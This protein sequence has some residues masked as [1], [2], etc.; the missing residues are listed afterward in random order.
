MGGFP[1]SAG[2]SHGKNEKA[3][4]GLQAKNILGSL[5]ACNEHKSEHPGAEV[6][7]DKVVARG[8]GL[9]QPKVPWQSH[10]AHNLTRRCQ[11]PCLQART[12]ARASSLKYAT[13]LEAPMKHPSRQTDSMRVHTDA[14]F[15]KGGGV[16][17]AYSATTL[18]F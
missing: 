11:C 12:V 15:S 14:K 8:G 1:A 10:K 2:V 18:S 7:L 17:T 13:T 3:G 5:C 9:L 6:L 16:P 4:R